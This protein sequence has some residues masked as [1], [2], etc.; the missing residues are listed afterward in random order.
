[1]FGFA[2]R[3]TIRRL[4]VT[5]G[6][7][8]VAM[9]FSVLTARWVAWVRFC[10]QKITRHRELES[11]YDALTRGYIFVDSSNKPLKVRARRFVTDY[12]ERAAHHHRMLQKWRRAAGR[13]WEQLEPD[14]PPP[15]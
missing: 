12:E 14:P 11:R 10:D 9:G 15:D 7:T 2:S 5:I 8:G 6:V 13:P 4:M 3:L 1:M